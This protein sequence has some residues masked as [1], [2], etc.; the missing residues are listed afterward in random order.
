MVEH[1][2]DARV[3]ADMMHYCRDFLEMPSVVLSWIEDGGCLSHPAGLIGLSLG[4][5]DD[6]N[7]MTIGQD[8]LVRSLLIEQPAT[9]CSFYCDLHAGQDRAYAD[10][11]SRHGFRYEV[12]LL[13]LDDDEPVAI[14]GLLDQQV[15]SDLSL[16]K[17]EALRRFMQQH[18]RFHPRIRH[19]RRRRVMR[20]R[21]ALT[22]REIEIADL[23]A[24][25][26]PNSTIAELLGIATSTAKTHLINIM[27]KLGTD[28]R[29]QIGA[30]V[31][32]M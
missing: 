18:I 13:L 15:R 8:P 24:A 29:I 17:T 28:S 22:A 19:Q 11:L 7:T 30:L 16:A 4:F 31:N 2:C 9:R 10:Y 23:V 5:I 6:Y 12:D 20:Q 26:A 14:L 32:R 21:Y 3:V 25:G 1:D 27:N